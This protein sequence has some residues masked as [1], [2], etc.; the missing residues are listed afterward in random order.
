MKIFPIL[1]IS[2][3]LLFISCG[4]DSVS[5]PIIPISEKGKFLPTSAY[6]GSKV[7]LYYKNLFRDSILG[8]FFS[9]KQA[10]IVSKSFDSI[11]VIVPNGIRGI[12]VVKLITNN[13]V[14]AFEQ[15]FEILKKPFDFTKII[16]ISCGMGYLHVLYNNYLWYKQVNIKGTVD[17]I[18]HSDTTEKINYTN[19]YNNKIPLKC[20]SVGVNKYNLLNSNAEKFN[21]DFEVNTSEKKFNFFN[22]EIIE[23]INN[24]PNYFFKFI[25]KMEDVPYGVND[26]TDFN[27]STVLVNIKGKKLNDCIKEFYISNYEYE[28]FPDKEIGRYTLKEAYKFLEQSD[29]SRIGFALSQKLF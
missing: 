12:V 18:R 29:T 23:P 15:D 27:F 22:I 2:F 11:F 8:V 24:S 17:T 16:S 26:S 14:M 3:T 1:L 6:N 10:D 25:L 13:K 9:D 4:D 19:G 21:V 28:Y 5:A 7:K 20:N